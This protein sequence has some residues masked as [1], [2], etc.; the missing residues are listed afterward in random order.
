[1]SKYDLS[2]IDSTNIG[3][4]LVVV[5]TGNDIG[6]LTGGAFTIGVLQGAGAQGKGWTGVSYDVVTG[7]FVFTS[8][9]GIGYT[10]DNITADLD[11]AVAA[12]QAAEAATEFLFNQFGDQYLGA[13]TT[14]PTV[15]TS[16]NPLTDGD[17]YFNTTDSVLKFYTGTAWV[18]PEAVATTAASEAQAAQVAAELA[19]TNAATSASNAATSESNALASEL[20]AA[21][22]ETNAASSESNA[23]TSETN[24]ATS[25]STAT[26]KASEASTSASNAATSESNA[27]TSESNALASELAA[28]TSE[29]NA[30]TSASNAATSETNAAASAAAAAA[31]SIIYAIALG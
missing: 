29:S 27:A 22:S 30:S 24:A 6:T 25:A 9:D 18:A 31:T 20:A 3:T 17:I 14:D 28:S 23:A 4:N 5:D 10:S 2:I 26:T 21:T 11:A 19:E 1:M 15:D 13:H 7:K 16:G 8:D 12:A